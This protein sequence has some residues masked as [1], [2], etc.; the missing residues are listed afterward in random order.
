MP[1]KRPLIACV[2]ASFW[3][4]CST[5][6]VWQRVPPDVRQRWAEVEDA[7]RQ[8]AIVPSLDIRD[9]KV[10]LLALQQIEAITTAG[11]EDCERDLSKSVIQEASNRI[12]EALDAMLRGMPAGQTATV[13]SVQAAIRAAASN[14]LDDAW[15][16]RHGMIP[17]SMDHRF[18][19][20]LV[21]LNL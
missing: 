11:V 14:A 21:V 5:G 6:G 15:M 2:R 4:K 1:A 7:S 3:E 20:Y 10:L 12:D 17:P 9:T 18:N 13:E 8:N 19:P 16:L